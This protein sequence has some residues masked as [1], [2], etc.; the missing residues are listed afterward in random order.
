MRY[1]LMALWDITALLLDAIY[2][3][4]RYGESITDRLTFEELQSRHILKMLDR[5]EK[6]RR[7]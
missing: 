1:Y 2:Q 6:C 7:P 3:K 4:I 5:M